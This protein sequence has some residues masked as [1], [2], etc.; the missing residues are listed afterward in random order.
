[1]SVREAPAEITVIG[2]LALHRVEVALI[3]LAEAEDG[4]LVGVAPVEV[5]GIG[6]RVAII[7]SDGAETRAALLPPLLAGELVGHALRASNE[8]QAEGRA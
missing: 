5:S 1:V 4:T 7:I 8:I 2:V 6:R 3:D